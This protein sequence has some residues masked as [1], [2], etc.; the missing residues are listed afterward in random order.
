VKHVFVAVAVCAAQAGCDRHAQTTGALSLRDSAG[1]S[2][3]A[4]PTDSSELVTW[5][6]SDSPDVSVGAAEGEEL[7]WVQGAGQFRDGSFAVANAGTHE[8]RFFARDGTLQHSTGREGAGPNEFL[9]F[10]WLRIRGDSLMVFDLQ[11]Q[12]L[13]I[14]DQAGRFVRLVSV[15]GLG[16]RGFSEVIGVFDNGSMLVATHESAGDRLEPGMRQIFRRYNVL[17]PDTSVARLQPLFLGDEFVERIADGYIMM[18]MPFGRVAAT[19]VAGNDWLYT[20]GTEYRVEQFDEQGRLRSIYVYPQQPPAVTQQDLEAFLPERLRQSVD[21]PRL[22][23]IYRKM[24]L[25]ERMPAYRELITDRDGNIWAAVHPGAST[26]RCWHV[27][28]PT[29]KSFAVICLPNQFDL[30]DAGSDYVLGVVRDAED[31]E[32]VERYALFKQENTATMPRRP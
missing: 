4:A 15:A 28:Q 1:V 11:N 24:P 26:R 16:Q 20:A 29:P 32:R 9:S 14:L 10:R 5:T 25:P 27:Y 3:I 31:V 19:A 17:R 12:R 6:V 2:I 30:Y 21:P 7:F 22:E 13:S 8:L 23:R 18:A